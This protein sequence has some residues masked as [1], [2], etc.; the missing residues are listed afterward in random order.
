MAEAQPVPQEARRVNRIG[1]LPHGYWASDKMRD[2]KVMGKVLALR[3]HLSA[4]AASLEMRAMA[5][6]AREKGEE[7]PEAVISLGYFDPTVSRLMTDSMEN[8]GTPRNSVIQEDTTFSTGGEIKRALEIAKERGWT[9]IIDIAFATHYRSI[10]LLLNKLAKGVNVEFKSVEDI[11]KERDVHRFSRDYLKRTTNEDG[12]VTEIPVHIDH[13]HNHTTHLLRR[14][15]RSRF[16]AAFRVYEMGKRAVYKFVDP[17]VL[18]ERNKK[19]RTEKEPIKESLYPLDVSRHKGQWAEGPFV[20]TLLR[21]NSKL[22]EIKAKIHPEP[23]KA[24]IATG[25]KVEVFPAGSIQRTG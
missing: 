25:V 15:R 10:R 17:D 24:K 9:Q 5:K 23:K 14:L 7:E 1:I 8:Y 6:Q 21:I 11:L 19:L 3:S 2:G 18:E 16:E 12:T 20:P 4:K 13:E 22:K